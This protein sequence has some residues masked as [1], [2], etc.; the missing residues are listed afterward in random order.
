MLDGFKC[1][2]VGLDA[3]VWKNTPRLD[4][5]L[6]VSSNTGE[7]LPERSKAKAESLTFSIK[8]NTVNNGSCWLAGSLHKFKN[9]PGCYN[10]DRFYFPEVVSTLER[11]KNE[12]GIDLENAELHGL[13]IGVNVILNY[14]PKR[15]FKSAICHNGQPFDNIDTRNKHLGI[16]CEHT[17][18][19]IKLYDKGKQAQVTQ[20]NGYILRVEV[21]VK[22]QRL[23][24]PYGI[25]TLSDLQSVEKVATL[26]NVLTDKLSGIVFFDFSLNTSNMS[27]AKRLNWERFSNPKY[28]EDLDKNKAYKARKQLESL[29][30]KYNAIDGGRLLTEKVV[31]EWI[32]L[33]GLKIENGH[34]SPLPEYAKL[35][36][37]KHTKKATISDLEYVVEK[38]AIGDHKTERKTP[39]YTGSKSKG[40]IPVTSSPKKK[41]PEKRFCAICGREI[42]HLRKD[43]RFCSEKER[44]KEAKQCRNK[45]SNRRLSI[46]R[47]IK[48]AMAK[49]KLL[50]VTYT[51]PSGNEY[52]DILGTNEINVTREWLD[53]VISVEVL[54]EAVKTVLEGKEAMNYLQTIKQ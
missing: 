36:K 48:K 19:T 15:I 33:A 13:E 12:Y 5:K 47:K 31:N 9:A 42:T 46:K 27:D 29:T 14:S 7:L 49:E 53:R 38:V 1:S 52:S 6:S 3:G 45:E 32:I 39:P 26:L 18:Y 44:G 43:A 16:I 4:F 41:P 2:C 11:L 35:W 51:D 21:K 22:R 10:W 24:E 37:S 28:W 23:L 54:D 8:E 20:N 40:K 34:I 17:D 30:Q 50:R 25:R